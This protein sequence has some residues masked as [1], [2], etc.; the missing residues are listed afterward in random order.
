M[1]GQTMSDV[2]AMLSST[3]MILPEPKQ[4]AYFHVRVATEEMSTVDE[5][6]SANDVTISSPRG[7]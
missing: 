3:S 4:P 7:R 2:V 1:I 5:P 6:C